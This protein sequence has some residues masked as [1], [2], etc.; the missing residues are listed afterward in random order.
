[1]WIH[2]WITVWVSQGT[3]YSKTYV[4]LTRC[5]T[6]FSVI[7]VGYHTEVLQ[8]P[9]LCCSVLSR[10]VPSNTL[11]PQGRLPG[12]SVHGG[13]L[14]KNIGMGCHTLIQGIFPTQR[15]DPGLPHCRQI[16]YQLGHQG[17]PWIL[18]RVAYPFSRDL[19]NPGV[20]PGSP[21]LQ[22]DSLPTEL[23]GKPQQPMRSKLVTLLFPFYR[24]GNQGTQSFSGFVQDY[25]AASRG[26]NYNH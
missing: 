25:S 9:M 23:P 5:Q 3:S 4:E 20:E 8:Q 14:G 19:L 18:E 22:V 13:S 26:H 10:L 21:A 6:P 16:L 7:F 17:S 1:M 15:S 2:G 24:R 11:R 12:S